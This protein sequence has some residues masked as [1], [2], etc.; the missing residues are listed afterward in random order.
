VRIT[1][2]SDR[3]RHE[4][5]VHLNMSLVQAVTEPEP[6]DDEWRIDIHDDFYTVGPEDG[7]KILNLFYAQNADVSVLADAELEAEWQRTEARL[8]RIGEE[9]RRRRAHGK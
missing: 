9:M 6:G 3:G 7:Q 4:R 2:L 8:T 5:K 1:T